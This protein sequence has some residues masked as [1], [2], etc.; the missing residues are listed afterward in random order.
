MTSAGKPAGPS[1]D[2]VD[3]EF[4]SGEDDFF[5]LQIRLGGR[6]TRERRENHMGNA[7][8][9]HKPAFA[10][11]GDADFSRNATSAAISPTFHGVFIVERF[12]AA[13]ASAM[14]SRSRFCGHSFTRTH[15]PQHVVCRMLPNHHRIVTA[16]AGRWTMPLTL[17]V[18]LGC[19]AGPPPFVYD[20]PLVEPTR[21][22]QPDRAAIAMITRTQP[23]VSADPTAVSDVSW[24]AIF[25]VNR[26]STTMHRIN[27]VWP[28]GGPRLVW[29]TPVGTGYGSVVTA[30]GFVVFNHRVGDQELV[31]CHAAVDGTPR[32][33]HEFPTTAVCEF[34]YSDG[35]YS[36]PIID[37][38]ANRV[39]NVSAQG[40][41]DCLNFESGDLLWS[42]DL[43]SDYDV[44]ADI[45][46]V[47]ASPLLDRDNE[48]PSGQLIF[49]LGA[50]DAG[51]VSI[52]AGTGH[53]IWSATN[54]G[55]AYATP[56]V[57]RIHGQRFG[58][59]LTDEGLVC[60]DPDSGRVDWE[61]TY[62]NRGD[63]ARNATSPAVIGDRVL[64]ITNGLGAICVQVQP[65]RSFQ[66]L[67]RQRRTIDSQYNTVMTDA[68][69]AYSFTAGGQGGAEFRCID[70]TDGTVAWSYHS[71]LK[72]GMGL[73]TPDAFL[74]L[75]EKGHLASLRRT[76]QSPIVL[77]F[78][79]EP[80]MTEPC[81][82]SP[83]IDARH[84]FLKDETRVAAFALE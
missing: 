21:A 24:P 31:Q 6:R 66:R 83:A 26:D 30:G 28:P 4:D 64:V 27:P 13:A 33:K 69:H 17:A 32:W 75:G 68:D 57:G 11:A 44:P 63:L 58:F 18:L 78:T 43:H 76:A 53:T 38:A 81:Y 72:R 2:E 5:T 23:S 54:H 67:W 79:S 22:D 35:P 70:L 34:E 74:L 80:L 36:T 15:F 71:V 1:V 10:V 49:N 48:L 61:I 84:L 59:V 52:D 39:F 29:E 25:G 60:L 62:R 9:H 41:L 37:V 42:R 56:W 14:L 47:G 55:P 77:S 82:C 7:I 45:F 50:A 46:P 40:R 3:S 65:D 8:R 20:R 16:A 19:D 73:A 51:V 12:S